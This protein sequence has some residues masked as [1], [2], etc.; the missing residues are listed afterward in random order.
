MFVHT[1]GDVVCFG[2]LVMCEGLVGLMSDIIRWAETAS[3]EYP[4]FLRFWE[5]RLLN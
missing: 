5:F 2:E 1:T 3:L 4:K